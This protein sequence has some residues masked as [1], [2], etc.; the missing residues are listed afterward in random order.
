MKINRESARLRCVKLKNSPRHKIVKCCKCGDEYLW[1][2]MWVVKRLNA[3]PQS[4]TEWHREYYC[5]EC[6]PTKKSVLEEIFHG[7]SQINKRGIYPVD[8]KKWFKNSAF[9]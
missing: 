9:K 6:C 7:E 3:L 4:T 1:G 8:C 5:L 2:K